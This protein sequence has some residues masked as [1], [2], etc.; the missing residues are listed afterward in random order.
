MI[1]A[2]LAVAAAKPSSP[3]YGKPEITIVSQTDVRNEDGSSAWR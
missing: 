2:L 3:A 1:A